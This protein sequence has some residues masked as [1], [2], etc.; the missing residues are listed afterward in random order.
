M[1]SGGNR[2]KPAP[3]GG[4]PASNSAVAFGSRGFGILDGFDS[5][6]T[7]AQDY[8]F[9]TTKGAAPLSLGRKSPHE[10]KFT[11]VVLEPLSDFRSGPEL[12]LFTAI[13]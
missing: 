10:A 4:G 13:Q 9:A 2:E 6:R 11:F 8:A 3:G 5:Q 12:E 1:N 7:C